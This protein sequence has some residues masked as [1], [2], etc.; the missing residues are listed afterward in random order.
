MIPISKTNV[1]KS[2]YEA[3]KCKIYLISI[4]SVMAASPGAPGED[5][6]IVDGGNF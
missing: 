6:E 4:E 3:P 1:F 2:P 5:D